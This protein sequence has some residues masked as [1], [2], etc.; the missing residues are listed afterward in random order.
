MHVFFCC[1]TEHQNGHIG[2]ESPTL[3]TT[4]PST[5]HAQQNGQTDATP[6]QANCDTTSVITT[7]NKPSVHSLQQSSQQVC[8]SV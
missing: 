1:S 3:I 8:A 2:S 6:L 5:T 7:S 4:S